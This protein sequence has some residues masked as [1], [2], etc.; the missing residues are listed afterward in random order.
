MIANIGYILLVLGVVCSALAALLC[1]LAVLKK[2][3]SFVL[4]TRILSGI[5]ALALGA[6]FILILVLLVGGHFDYEIVYDHTSLQMNTLQKI[7]AAWGNKNGSLLFWSLLLALTV[8]ISAWGKWRGSKQA[9]FHE[10]MLLLNLF[11]LFF[12][13][14]VTFQTNPFARLWQLANGDIVA[15]LFAPAGALPFSPPDG[16]G[17]NPLLK[18]VGMVIHPPLLYLGFIMFFVPFAFAIVSLWR[19]DYS[20]TW[21][22]STRT[23]IILA[24]VFLTAGILLGCWWAYEI[25][26]WG[27]YWSW[28]P[29][30]I[31]GLMPW[32]SGLALLH[33]L[34]VYTA[35]ERVRRWAYVQVIGTMLLIIFGIYL[36]RTGAVSSVHAYSQSNIGPPFMGFFIFLLLLSIGS[37]C[38]RWRELKPQAPRQPF[39]TREGLTLTLQAGLTLLVL[40]CLAGV[41]LPLTSRAVSGQAT[42]PSQIFY[43]WNFAPVLIVIFVITALGFLPN[44][45]NLRTLL[46]LIGFVL[47]VLV[48]IL[49][50][51]LNVPALFGLW[52]V[53]FTLTALLLAAGYRLRRSTSGGGSWLA[54]LASLL[55]H[56]GFALLA[57]GVVGSRTL[58]DS[59]VVSLDVGQST[60]VGKWQVSKG[61]S[62]VEAAADAQVL[63]A[64]QYTFQRAGGSALALHPQVLWYADT[65]SSVS[66]P[67]IHSDVAGDTYAAI[68]EWDGNAAGETIVLLSYF[69]F[70]MWLWIGGILVMVG[71][72]GYLFAASPALKPLRAD[73]LPQKS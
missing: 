23:W 28:D 46:V 21:L 20:S 33:C 54:R 37:L 40:I 67:A 11:T 22:S 42:E 36:S 16:Q 12:V 57:L 70:M 48:G 26:G 25:L 27:G 47:T 8:A 68:L 71:A 66:S 50:G 55:L 72:L 7:T 34:E 29:V 6:A 59:S 10:V 31:A 60:T 63:Y 13:A 24:W 30:E 14:L 53:F 58:P 9:Y 35:S 1:L 38:A 61:V 39:L 4:E 17:L 2:E 18:H 73:D 5:T 62:E 56:I 43:E 41:T 19:R 44:K 49:Y 45:K 69:P 64:E 3:R 15:S 52:T 51:K 32:L 65:R